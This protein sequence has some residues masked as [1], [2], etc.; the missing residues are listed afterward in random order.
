M[1][2]QWRT[3]VVAQ[4]KTHIPSPLPAQRLLYSSEL[5]DSALSHQ[6]LSGWR[7]R[8]GGLLNCAARPSRCLSRLGRDVCGRAA[9]S[10]QLDNPTGDRRLR[11]SLQALVIIAG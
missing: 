10:D 9:I 4:N 3:S 6:V 1:S 5:V 2:N 11:A 8:I 7:R